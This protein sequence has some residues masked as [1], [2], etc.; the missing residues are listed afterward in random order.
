MSGT[1]DLCYTTARYLSALFTLRLFVSG[2]FHLRRCISVRS[3]DTFSLYQYLLRLSIGN[4]RSVLY[5]DSRDGYPPLL[6]Y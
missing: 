5:L 4:G 1:L 2:D 6:V 3:V